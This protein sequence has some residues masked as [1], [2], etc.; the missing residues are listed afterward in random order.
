MAAVRACSPWIVSRRDAAN[1]PNWIR[2]RSERLDGH[3]PA[4]WSRANPVDIVGDAPATR[5][6]A[7]VDAVAEDRDVDVVL[8]MNCP[9]ALASPADAAR[10]VAGEVRKGMIGRKPVLSCWLGGATARDARRIL[11]EAGVAS[12]DTPATAAA[13]VGHLTDWGR[14]QEALLRMPDRVGGG[15]LAQ[16]ACRRA[17]GR[18][19][20]RSRPSRQRDGR[21]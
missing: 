4:N 11:R 7:A 21:C 14:A 5:Y 10:A 6:L 19:A 3:L 17:R 20:R 16:D 13:A 2:R 15:D 1:W 18:R 8:V 12:Y 9:T